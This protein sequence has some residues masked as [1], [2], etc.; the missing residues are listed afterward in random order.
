MNLKLQVHLEHPTISISQSSQIGKAL[1]RLLRLSLLPNLSRVML[2]QQCL[3]KTRELAKLVLAR[4]TELVLFKPILLE[5]I[6]QLSQNW[7]SKR[8]LPLWINRLFIIAQTNSIACNLKIKCQ[9]TYSQIIINKIHN[10]QLW[11]TFNLRM[12]LSEEKVNLLNL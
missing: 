4:P 10:C 5:R 3:I 9:L 11:I 6:L 12:S 1:I 7:R 2:P 8:R